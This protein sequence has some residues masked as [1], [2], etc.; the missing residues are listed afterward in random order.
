MRYLVLMGTLLVAGLALA[1]TGLHL[2]PAKRFEFTDCASGGSAAQTVT[3][4][5]Y[6]FRVTDADVF[7]CFADSASTCAT[8]GEKFPS[9]TVVS[10]SIGGGGQSVSC[11][12]SASTGDV[13]LTNV[14]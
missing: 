7:L 6:L 13:I 1:A 4:G 8:G 12:S 3:G 10:L 14:D 9:G 2:N 11:R 5:V